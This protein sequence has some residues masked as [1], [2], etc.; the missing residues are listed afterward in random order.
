LGWIGTQP[1]EFPYISISQCCTLLYFSFFF[2]IIP[3]VSFI[4]NKLVFETYSKT[5]S[6]LC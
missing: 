2:I 1:V 5:D 4:E 6:V 3:F